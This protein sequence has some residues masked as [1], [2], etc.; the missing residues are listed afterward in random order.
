M[1]GRCAHDRNPR[2][3]QKA[4]PHGVHDFSAQKRGTRAL[5]KRGTRESPLVAYNTC[6]TKRGGVYPGPA[7]YGCGVSGPG[8]RVCSKLGAFG[9]LDLFQFGHLGSLPNGIWVGRFRAQKT[10]IPCGLAPICLKHSDDGCQHVF[11]FGCFLEPRTGSINTRKKRGTRA[12]KKRGTPPTVTPGPAFA[13]SFFGRGC[14]LDFPM[15]SHTRLTDGCDQKCGKSTLFRRRS[16]PSYRRVGPKVRGIDTFSGAS[17]GRRIAVGLT[18]GA[19]EQL[20][21]EL[22]GSCRANRFE[23][24]WRFWIVRMPA[25]DAGSWHTAALAIRGDPWLRANVVTLRISQPLWET[26]PA[27]AAGVALPVV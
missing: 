26:D 3:V 2:L 8:S 9:A 25:P 10:C 13:Q 6:P 16:H 20:S 17:G 11:G 23:C 22:R 7:L 18:A 19:L 24:T 15:F 4:I 1:F 12:L 14:P 21:N 5:S 27:G